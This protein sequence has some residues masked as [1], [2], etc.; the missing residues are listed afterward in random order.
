[1]EDES[2][3]NTRIHGILAELPCLIQPKLTFSFRKDRKTVDQL[4]VFSGSPLLHRVILIN[5]LVKL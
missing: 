2:Q 1:M 3:T 5:V 4:T